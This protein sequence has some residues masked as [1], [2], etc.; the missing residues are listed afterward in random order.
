MLEKHEDIKTNHLLF[1]LPF[2]L[3]SLLLRITLNCVAFSVFASKYTL[4]SFQVKEKKEKIK[5][6]TAHGIYSLNNK[7][8]PTYVSNYGVRT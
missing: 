8:H 1:F 2:S 3:F 7:H 4:Y 6:G 5:R